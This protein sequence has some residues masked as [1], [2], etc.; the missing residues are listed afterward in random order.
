MALFRRKETMQSEDRTGT[1]NPREKEA[2]GPKCK[3]RTGQVDT[4]RKDR[5]SRC[6][7]CA[8]EAVLV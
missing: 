8:G 2:T 7:W 1:A 5:E 4:R 3:D 6:G